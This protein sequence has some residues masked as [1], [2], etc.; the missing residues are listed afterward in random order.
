[1]VE[2]RGAMIGHKLPGSGLKYKLSYRGGRNQPEHILG[3]FPSPTA[4]GWLWRFLNGPLI[5]ARCY[6]D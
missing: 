3:A 5:L 4:D 2:D 1:M 6:K